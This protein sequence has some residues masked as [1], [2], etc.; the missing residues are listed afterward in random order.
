MATAVVG[1]GCMQGD[2]PFGILSWKG[3]PALYLR[4][5]C[6]WCTLDVMRRVAWVFN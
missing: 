3:A 5:L 1:S 6:G 4:F 2:C